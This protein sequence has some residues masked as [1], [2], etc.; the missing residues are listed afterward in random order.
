MFDWLQR[1]SHAWS[2]RRQGATGNA[3]KLTARRIFVLPT[4]QGLVLVVTLLILWI[5]DINYNLNLGFMLTFLLLAVA[6]LS[7][8]HT[9]RN[10]A[11]LE[12]R[13]GRIEPVFAGD[14]AEFVFHV[15]NPY[16]VARYRIALSEL[17][18]HAATF[19]VAAQAE[20][21]VRLTLPS[22]HRGWLEAQRL[23]LRCDFP[24]GLFQAWAFLPLEAFCLVYPRPAET[25]P[26]PTLLTD[27]D[28]ERT[29]PNGVEDFAGLRGYVP[30]DSM[31]RIAWKT[32]AREQGLLV[33]QFDSPKGVLIWLDWDALP[34]TTEEHCLSQLT[35][36]VL[37]ADKANLAYGLRLPGLECGIGLGERHRAEC[38]QMLALFDHRGQ[39]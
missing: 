36:W 20:T 9:Y 19:D 26:L 2:I 10:L 33:K 7:L 4:R 17:L 30:G 15:R 28:G 21:E 8:F 23:E 27:E 32:L 11:G 12:V 25:C 37:D 18:G 29:L 39:L 22:T 14:S 5:G 1:R 34:R 31:S 3:V 16:A 38:L 24:L 35:R 6:V 13:T